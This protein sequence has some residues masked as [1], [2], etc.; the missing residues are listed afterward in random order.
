[1]EEKEEE[2]C[3][4]KKCQTRLEDFGFTFGGVE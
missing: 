3:M 2:I 4:C 1:M